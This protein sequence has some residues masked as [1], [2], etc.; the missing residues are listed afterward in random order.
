VELETYF[1]EQGWTIAFRESRPARQ[2]EF[3]AFH[4]LGLSDFSLRVLD[5]FDRGL[6][7]PQ[8]EGIRR[9]LSGSNL[10]VTTSTAS[11][12]TLIFNVC[13]L[14]ELAR[15]ANTRIAAVYPLTLQRHLT[16]GL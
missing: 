7:Q 1:A 12:K 11:G 13:A 3:F 16:H 14:E 2:G 15:Q 10:A 9:Y 4:D 8:R 5:G 6:Y